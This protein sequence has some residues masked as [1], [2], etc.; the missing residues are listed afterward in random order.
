MAEGDQLNAARSLAVPNLTAPAAPEAITID[1]SLVDVS[2]S[3]L[4]QLNVRS[5]TR[6]K[7]AS[8]SK[9]EPDYPLMT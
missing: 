9:V 7:I 6:L 2:V 3:M 8:R 1:E 4:T 5:T